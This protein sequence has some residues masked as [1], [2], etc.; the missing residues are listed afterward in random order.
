[1][2]GGGETN[3]TTYLN[4]AHW[5]SSAQQWGDPSTGTGAGNGWM[6]IREG[7]SEG[8]LKSS[9]KE[10]LEA[11]PGSPSGIYTIDFTQGSPNDKATV[12]CDMTTSGGGWTLVAY[13]NGTATGSTP[14]NFFVSAVNL[15]LIAEHTRTN[16]QAS[17]NPELFSLNVGTTDAMFISPSYNSGAA[18]IDTNFGPWDYN[19][20]KCSGT[21]YHTSR[22]AGCTGQNAND[23]FDTADAFNLS[24]FTGN[25]GIV[26]AY[27]AT[28]V[29]YSGKGSCS[30]KFFLR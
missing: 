25:E 15:P 20:T 10:I 12:Y 24:F 16:Y 13:S 28:E 27:K 30:F 23:N 29:C 7:K 9:C 14:N 19:K 5:A 2:N 4:G 22:T 3:T 1:M 17:L 26:P 6:F 18:I 8:R 21:L 11:N